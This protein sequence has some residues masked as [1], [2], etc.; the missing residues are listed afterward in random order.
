[1]GAF[2]AAGKN[3]MLDAIGGTNPALSITHAGLMTKQA[4]RNVTGTASTD[5]IAD[6][7]TPYANGDVV[8]FSAINGGA[9][10]VVG[11]PYFVVNKNTNDQ[12]D[13]LDAVLRARPRPRSRLMPRLGV[14]PFVGACSDGLCYGV[15][16]NL[17]WSPFR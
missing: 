6:T 8:V 13:S 10:L 11:R 9:G 3:V 14:G 15:G 2:T 12:I 4:G 1:M 16:V 5:V 7:A 17:S